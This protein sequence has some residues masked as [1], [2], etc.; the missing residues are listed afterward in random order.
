MRSYTGSSSVTGTSSSSITGS[1]SPSQT[2]T[3]STSISSLFLSVNQ[4]NVSKNS[5]LNIGGI[6]AGS[7]IGLIGLIACLVVLYQYIQRK[8]INS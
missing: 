7:I 1:E 2:G 5:N 8:R 3:A 4:S 6:T